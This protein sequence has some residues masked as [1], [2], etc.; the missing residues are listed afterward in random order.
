MLGAILGV[1]RPAR[2][3]YGAACLAMCALLGC[4]I[5]TFAL[6]AP[7]APPPS[8]ADNAVRSVWSGGLDGAALT[9]TRVR[10]LAEFFP[11]LAP[12]WMAGVLIFY[13]RHLASWLA[14]RRWSRT[15]V[16]HAPDLWQQ[17]LGTLAER[18]G[19]RRPVALVESCLARV[20]VVMGHLRPVILMPVGL[21]TSLPLG[22]IESILLHE[23]AH[24][25]RY[26]YLANLVETSVESLL[27]YHPL[28][29]WISRVIRAEREHCAD[30]LAAALTGNPQ[31]YARALVALEENCWGASEAALAATGGDLMKRIRRLLV[32]TEQAN[33][34]IGAAFA[35]C[36]LALAAIGL[37]VWQA[38]AQAPPEQAQQVSPY[39]RWLNEDV[40]YIITDRERLA[41]QALRT[42]DERQHFIEQFWLRR[43]PTP[44]TPENEF[45]EEHYQRIQ[46]A[47]DHFA[48][49]L[50]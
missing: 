18:L 11:W 34:G 23:L 37:F 6:S 44:G 47:N 22:Q 38:K 32:P 31:E 2:P 41:F 42:D 1:V 27:F 10:G 40:A 33:S 12:F 17:R 21:L 5:A 35:A 49:S 28:V 14:A 45:K 36:M 13:L 24:I 9:A 43:D 4:F 30:D 16:C 39:T 25:V 50:P 20:P 3:R 7:H 48:S 26:D 19:I 29:W 8:A 15:G 46:Y